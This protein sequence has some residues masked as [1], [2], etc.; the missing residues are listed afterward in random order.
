MGMKCAQTGAF[1]FYPRSIP[2]GPRA[3]A[4][5]IAT[6]SP[7]L[8]KRAGLK[9]LDR[10]AECKV[11]KSPVVV[12]DFR[13]KRNGICSASESVFWRPGEDNIVVTSAVQ[14]LLSKWT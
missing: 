7:G 14:F 11:A 10:A 5:N 12:A 3:A 9:H 2:W 1:I 13:I 4:G 6:G 8:L